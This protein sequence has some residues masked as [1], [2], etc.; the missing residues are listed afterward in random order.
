[1]NIHSTRQGIAVVFTSKHY[2]VIY[3][4]YSTLNN[5]LFLDKK[6][7]IF[8]SKKAQKGRWH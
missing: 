6:I 2:R 5:A 4:N 1:V 3:Q 8:L 7:E